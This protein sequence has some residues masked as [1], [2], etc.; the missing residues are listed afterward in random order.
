[1]AA[2]QLLQPPVR[3]KLPAVVDNDLG[4]A[5][6]DE[7]DYSLV[8]P[9][10]MFAN[11]SN[12]I[13]MVQAMK[14]ARTLISA[15]YFTQALPQREQEAPYVDALDESEGVG[16]GRV[17][18]RKLGFRPSLYDGEVTS[19]GRGKITF[20]DSR[21]KRQEQEIHSYFPHARKTFTHDTPLV[22]IGDQVK[23]GQ[24][25]ARSNF[26]TD[27]GDLALGRN[28]RVAFMAAPEGSSFEDAIAVS[29]SAAHKMTST[30]LYSHDIDLDHGVI[31]NKKKFV[32]QYPNRFTKQQLA[33][34]DENGMA[35]PGITLEPGD[36][37]ALS[38]K[39][40]IL[41]SKDAA[42][43]S[44][45]KVMRNTFLDNSVVWEKP[46][47]GV[48]A[49]SYLGNKALKVNIATNM[50]LQE[51]DKISARQGAKGVIGKI[52]PDERMPHDADGN[53]VDIFIN[54]AALIGRVNPA[55]VYE[56]LLG[57]VA[58]KTGKRYALP[59]FSEGSVQALVANELAKNKISDVET[60][61]DP[62]TGRSI[63]GILTGNQYFMK[64]EHTSE[65]FDDQTEVL[66]DSGWKLWKDVTM[67][68]RLATSDT[69][70]QSLFFEQ[71]LH[72]VQYHYMGELCAFSGKYVDYVVTPNHNL[73]CRVYHGSGRTF[74]LRQAGEMQGREFTVKQFCFDVESHGAGPF[75]LGDRSLD[76]DDMCEL[77][78]WWVTEGCVNTNGDA[79]V[80][81]QSST[82]NPERLQAIKDLVDR[83]GFSWSPYKSDGVEGGVLIKDKDLA[84]YLS[85]Y[86]STC[87]HKRV[88]REV[89]TGPL[90]GVIRCIESML[91]GDGSYQKTQ[92]GPSVHLVS[93]SKGLVD[94]FQE[95]AIRAGWGSVVREDSREW[96]KYRENPHYLTAW[97]A[98][99]TKT[100]ANSL[101]DGKRNP[102][103]F[104]MIP[105]DGMV[106][107]AEMRTGLLY[108]R[109]NGK[110]MLSGN[111]KL[112][113]RDE[114]G[115]DINEQPT[116]GG[117][118]GA[119][120]LGGLMDAA[121]LAH[122]ATE[123]LRDKQV[124]RGSGNPEMFRAIRAGRPL[125][126]PEVPFIYNK[127]LNTLR[128]AG[129]RVDEQPDR[130]AITAM[131]DM[132]VDELGPMEINSGQTIDEKTGE[133]IK[134]GLFDFSLFG[135][136]EQKG[137]GKVTLD[138]PMPNPIMEESV[139]S[140]LGLTERQ[141]RDV[142]TGRHSV[143]GGTGPS[144][145]MKALDGVDLDRLEEETINSVRYGRKSHRNNAIKK[146][147]AIRGL[148]TAGLEASDM[149]V[150]KIPVLP[151][152]YRPAM[153]M[154]DVTIV[155]DS[156]YLYK[157][158][159]S[160]RDVFRG[161]KQILPDTE[162]GDERLAVYDSIRAVQGL[163]EPIH[164]ETR[165]KGVKGFM[166]VI[167]GAGRG[168]KMGMFQSKVLGHSV[169]TVGRS[170]IIPDSRLDMDH[171]GLPEKMA[172]AMYDP[173]V[174]GRMVRDG[175]GQSAA[176]RELEKHSE[177]AKSYLLKE[178]QDRPVLYSRDPALHKFSI[179]GAYPVLV[180]GDSI[181]I[182]PLVVGPFNAD[183]D[184]DAMNVHLPI[185][186]GA[187][188]EVRDKLM[189]SQNLFSIKDRSIHYKPSQ[190][191][192][193]GLYNAT[194]PAKN[195]ESR[196][197]DSQDAAIQAYQD[198]EIDI[199]T[200][201]VIS[202]S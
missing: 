144:G 69:R 114:G 180:P 5:F 154:G 107:C 169:N 164:Q 145:L 32:S 121:L 21:G 81:Y 192:I 4:M 94:D 147:N 11:T 115:V 89:I 67:A 178:M 68:D 157:D 46:S 113:G 61:I 133:P 176:A 152:A 201:I 167:T 100:R 28:L 123:V 158:L 42:L 80:I 181:R 127:Y 83:L 141:L 85:H 191:F 44:L 108:V 86:G 17:F 109:R 84:T 22:K 190:E 59:N 54:P 36:P 160:A 143:A 116:K 45:S 16:M 49:D 183:F 165:D 174:M 171:V 29:Q 170:V 14:G 13:P 196:R 31:A 132:D 37:V 151:P 149:M 128:A 75:R 198:N 173:F 142:I 185:S 8:S 23:A 177:M 33:K 10:Q 55:M 102:E 110:P 91:E 57:K 19:I 120:R 51:G 140:I 60:L 103:G 136:P 96:K 76:W 95:M 58:A 134:G 97:S 129:I 199:D 30:H 92:T 168:P 24:P 122:G 43:G 156:N 139:R 194:Q 202:S 99:F 2:E 106:Y 64:L 131:T 172:W 193:L 186:P 71:P 88:P 62:N 1:M 98:S 66:T 166:Q 74:L 188:R 163:G 39:P 159:L 48:V 52:I 79:A 20:K 118:E 189:P 195:K 187:V 53:P 50:P 117:K 9:N 175:M 90:S 41:S 12:L 35:K 111:S 130:V 101:V 72:L 184:G 47:P 6:E 15:K 146:L 56:A 124:Y 82:A 77:M 18:G 73:W 162:L 65:C 135:G 138:E 40:M 78:G 179:M 70:G 3:R 105:Y 27:D 155:S 26:V 93:T 161:N 182:S 38:M 150:T 25:I 87:E 63:D 126:T 104:S 148:K 197:F 112:S 119:K 200:P 34:L 137:W 7:S 153:K 125:P